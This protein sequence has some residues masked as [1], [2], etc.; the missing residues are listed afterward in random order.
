MIGEQGEDSEDTVAE[1]GGLGVDWAEGRTDSD[2][3]L[4][5]LA[6]LPSL[7]GLGELDISSEVDSK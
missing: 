7:L 4:L 6:I 2:M 1:C 5:H 3:E